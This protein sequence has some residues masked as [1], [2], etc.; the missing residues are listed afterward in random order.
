MEPALLTAIA[1]VSVGLL[2]VAIEILVIP[3]LGLAGILGCGTIVATAVW[4]YWRWGVLQAAVTLGSGVVAGLALLWLLPKTRAGKSMVLTAQSAGQAPAEELTR[5]L[6]REGLTTT[7]LRPSGSARFGQDLVDV[8][9]DGDYVA[10][11]T[12]VRVIRVEGVRVVVQ[13]LE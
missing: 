4:A 11:Q 13:P 3:G 10:P 8:V 9:A 5:L 7:A 1:L 12:A 2:L 6:G